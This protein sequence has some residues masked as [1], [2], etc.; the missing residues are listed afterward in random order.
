MNENRKLLTAC[1]VLAGAC[2]FFI[3]YFAGLHHEQRIVPCSGGSIHNI[4][5]ER[6]GFPQDAINANI[7]A[8]EL[9]W[10][11]RGIDPSRLHDPLP[12][13]PMNLWHELTPSPKYPDG[14]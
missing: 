11:R 6:Y 10:L 9:E 3:G 7:E 1:F 12:D 14:A 8:I 2:N 5:R 13:H 4:I